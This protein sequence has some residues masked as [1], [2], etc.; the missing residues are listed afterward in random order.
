M[1]TTCCNKPLNAREETHDK[2]SVILE[3]TK[4]TP[5]ALDLLDYVIDTYACVKKFLFLNY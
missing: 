2:F 5:V 3:Y 4:P 1:V